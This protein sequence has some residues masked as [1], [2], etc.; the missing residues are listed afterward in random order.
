MFSRG[1]IA[2][3]WV[4]PL[5][6]SVYFLYLLKISKSIRFLMFKR[7]IKREHLMGQVLII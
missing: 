2:P 1:N 6:C 7:G 4:N 5:L 3:K